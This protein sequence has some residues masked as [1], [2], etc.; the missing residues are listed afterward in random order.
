MSVS[1]QEIENAFQPAREIST[2]KRFAGR[3]VQVEDAYYGLI[4]EGANL[5]V[6]GN[7]GVGK[8]SLARQIVN[9]SVGENELLEK[10][11]IRH[12]GKLDFQS[13]YLAC[14]GR[15]NAY[16]DLL[17]HLLTT[18]DCLGDWVYDV[19][20]AR[21]ALD[22]IEPQLK[23]GFAS[24]GGKLQTET[25]STPAVGQHEIETVF[26]NVVSS[27]ADQKLTRSGLLFVIDEFDQIRDPSGFAGFL[28]SMATNAPSVKFCLV[29][30]AQDIQNLMKEH[31]S[32]DRLF[33]GS[34]ITLP[35]MSESELT[36]IV[37]IAE[38]TVDGAI[39]F[40]H[41]A[42]HSIA[43]LAQGHPYM[44]H[45]IG[46]Y[47]LREAFKQGAKEIGEEAVLQALKSIADRGADPVL[48]GRYK[49]AVAA[50]PQ[51]E[52]VL[53]AMAQSQGSD[54][55]VFT[56]NAYKLALDWG[57]DNSSQYVGQLVNDEYGGELVKIRERYYRFRDSLFR[58]YV[59][60]RPV[61]FPGHTQ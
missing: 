37:D 26:L 52:A 61:L 18:K 51:R 4:A 46:R 8:S 9:I 34:I 38:A 14:G 41:G 21:R 47:A 50:S 23:L 6:V 11:Q 57:V 1:L 58:A 2:A 56:T 25:Q 53:R 32:A 31:A 59:C 13:F 39:T 28:K 22:S 49:K 15:V 5:A 16:E 43:Q 33:A 19:P 3:R 45:L 12:S 44:V 55:E 24:L 30:V 60:A 10:L 7:R 48:E 42:K 29:G 35:G 20:S 36:E 27:L 40:T 54:G 17:K